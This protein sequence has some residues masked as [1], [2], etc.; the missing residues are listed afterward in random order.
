MSVNETDDIDLIKR[1]YLQQ[2]PARLFAFPDSLPSI[3]SSLW[4]AVLPA[5]ACLTPTN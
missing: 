5:C 3:Q 2:I 1:Q 4:D